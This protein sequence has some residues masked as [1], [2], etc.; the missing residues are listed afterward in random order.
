ME[1]FKFE[2]GVR[3]KPT[4]FYFTITCLQTWVVLLQ[5]VLSKYYWVLQKQYMYN[6]EHK[7]V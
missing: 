2:G 3:P 5:Y 1:Q 7:R 4:R 6:Y